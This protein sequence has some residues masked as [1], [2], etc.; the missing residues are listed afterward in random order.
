MKLTPAQIEQTTQ[1]I[2]AQL[3]PEESQLAPK[4]HKAYLCR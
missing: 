4:L 2:E 1:Q 3:V